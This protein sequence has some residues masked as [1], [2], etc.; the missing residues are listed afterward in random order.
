MVTNAKI[1]KT[2]PKSS[3]AGCGGRGSKGKKKR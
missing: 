3:S 2:Q 1:I